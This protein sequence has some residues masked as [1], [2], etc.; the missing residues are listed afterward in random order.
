MKFD[1]H[2]LKMRDD[3]FLVHVIMYVLSQVYIYYM[4]VCN[5]IKKKN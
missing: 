2:A 3:S 4:N 1:M 5:F